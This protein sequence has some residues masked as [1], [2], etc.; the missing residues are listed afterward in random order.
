MVAGERAEQDGGQT[1]AFR[2][3]GCGADGQMASDTDLELFG[4]FARII[5]GA[6]GGSQDM[7]RNG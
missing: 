5:F 1:D 6:F 2:R 4:G 3:P 7:E